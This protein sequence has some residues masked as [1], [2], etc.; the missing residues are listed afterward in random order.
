MINSLQTSINA[1][2]QNKIQL[3]EKDFKTIQKILLKHL[4]CSNSKV[5]AFGSRVKNTAKKYSDLDLL[6]YASSDEIFNLRVAFEESSLGFNVDVVDGSKVSD[7]FLNAIY[8]SLTKY[9]F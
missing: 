7:A 4:E 8:P 5:F 9:N 6:V 1:K 2:V 3:D